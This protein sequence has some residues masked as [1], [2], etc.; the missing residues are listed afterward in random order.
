MAASTLT[1]KKI[2]SS[3][4]LYNTNLIMCLH[5]EHFFIIVSCA[6]QKKNYKNLTL[7]PLM[8]CF[9]YSSL[10]PLFVWQ[11]PFLL[12][13]VTATLHQTELPG[14]PKCSH[15]MWYHQSL[16]GG[17]CS[18]SLKTE[19]LELL[20]NKCVAQGHF[21]RVNVCASL[22]GQLTLFAEGHHLRL[23]G[24]KQEALWLPDV[25]P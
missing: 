19:P 6:L 20:C 21:S 15:E 24:E 5:S 22:L 10:L 8:W 18:I 25:P 2:L 12:S 9:L 17:R 4:I 1:C 16:S 13:L 23:Y 11:P 3:S 7:P 14:K